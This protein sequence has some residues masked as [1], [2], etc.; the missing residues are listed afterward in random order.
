MEAYEV[1]QIVAKQQTQLEAC[2]SEYHSISA[3]REQ[4][5]HELNETDKKYRES[6]N[7]LMEAERK[8]EYYFTI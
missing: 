4:M 8:G 2:I 7:S 1:Q 5:E 3:S 6:L